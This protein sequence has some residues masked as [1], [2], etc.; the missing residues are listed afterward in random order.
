M[1]RNEAAIHLRATAGEKTIKLLLVETIFFLYIICPAK[2]KQWEKVEV[3]GRGGGGG[4]CGMWGGGGRKNDRGGR[5]G[6]QNERKSMVNC[7]R[8]GGN[9]ENFPGKILS[10]EGDENY[11]FALS[12]GP[13]KSI[14]P[15]QNNV[16]SDGGIEVYDV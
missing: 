12:S 10:L 8:I 14:S 4:G 5:K 11:Y 9:A 6:S 7:F 16:L 2:K 1:S 15:P 3:K 13:L